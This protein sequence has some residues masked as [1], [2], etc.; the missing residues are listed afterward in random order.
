MSSKTRLFFKR[1]P[2]ATL[3]SNRFLGVPIPLLVDRT[4]VISF[5]PNKIRVVEPWVPIFD[6]DGTKLAWWKGDQLF[7]ASPEAK[8][9]CEIVDAPGSKGIV[10]DGK[11]LFLIK[12][13]LSN[14]VR[15][16]G[17]LF[18]ARGHMMQVTEPSKSGRSEVVINDKAIVLPGSCTLSGNSIAG[19]QV[20]IYVDP[21]GGFSIGGSF[22]QG[23]IDLPDLGRDS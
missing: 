21:D 23:S 2:D 16:E 18:M 17:T 1:T 4:P 5:L 7:L 20:G 8:E 11:P 10:M 9:R 6:E 19:G 14:D 3:G 12:R 15:A 13:E 22:P